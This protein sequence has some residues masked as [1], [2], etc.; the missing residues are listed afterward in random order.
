MCRDDGVAR[1]LHGHIADAALAKHT[2]PAK[3]RRQVIGIAAGGK[4]LVVMIAAF[5]EG[6]S[7]PPYCTNES[8]KAFP[9]FCPAAS[10]CNRVNSGNCIARKKHTK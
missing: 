6:R 1:T 3:N 10:D 7:T 2:G 8:R 4:A 9:D 5:R